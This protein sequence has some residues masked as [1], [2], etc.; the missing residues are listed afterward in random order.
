MEQDSSQRVR[1]VV[2][3]SGGGEQELSLKIGDAGQKHQVN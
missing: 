2:L 1:E 3:S